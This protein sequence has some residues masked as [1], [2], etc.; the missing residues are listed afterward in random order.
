MGTGAV[1]WHSSEIAR[2]DTQTENKCTFYPTCLWDLPSHC[3]Y[4]SPIV[5]PAVWPTIISSTVL[6]SARVGIWTRPCGTTDPPETA[7][8][9]PDI[10]AN[11]NRLGT[12]KSTTIFNPLAT[13][14]IHVKYRRCLHHCKRHL[15][16]FLTVLTAPNLV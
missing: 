3:C 4:A 16:L 2:T 1:F 9:D 15:S 12:S 11:T 8:G 7:V 6:R 13:T 14:P 5:Q 10:R